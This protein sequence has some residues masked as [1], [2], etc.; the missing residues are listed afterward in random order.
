MNSAG[1]D[2]GAIIAAISVGFNILM[3]VMQSKIKADIAELRT[4]M[5][6]KFST[7]NDVY[8]MLRAARASSPLDED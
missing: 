5:Y 7:K 1:Q 3:I 4:E 2:W 8:R 6:E